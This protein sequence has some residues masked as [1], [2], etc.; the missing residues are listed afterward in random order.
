[1]PNDGAWGT[2][3]ILWQEQVTQD[4][5]ISLKDLV[6]KARAAQAGNDAES[7]GVRAF[8]SGVAN[9]GVIRGGGQLSS[10]GHLPS[11]AGGCGICGNSH[12]GECAF[13]STEARRRTTRTLQDVENVRWQRGSDFLTQR[14]GASIAANAV[15]WRATARRSS[16]TTTT[17]ATLIPIPTTTANA[18]IVA[19]AVIARRIVARNAKTASATRQRPS[20][21]LVV[22]VG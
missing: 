22:D 17:E 13:R 10:G 7:S 2:R 3:K 20:S 16:A 14:S 6:N 1:M 19:F 5:A 18:I 8:A 21:P 15:T 11:G 9:S 4:D 12:S